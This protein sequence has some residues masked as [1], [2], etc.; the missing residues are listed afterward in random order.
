[1]PQF[2]RSFHICMHDYISACSGRRAAC[3]KH[4][5]VSARSGRL[6][7]GRVPSMNGRPPAKPPQPKRLPL[8]LQTILLKSA[9]KRAAAQPESLRRLAC[10]A[11][12]ARQRFLD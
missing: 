4:N 12:G 1:M 2:A 8:Q 7:T 5:E 10:I 9:I 3:I 11:A 6:A